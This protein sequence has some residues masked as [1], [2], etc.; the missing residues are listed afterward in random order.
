LGKPTVAPARLK[1]TDGLI[2]WSRPALA[3]KNQ[4][5]AMEPWPRNYTFWH[6][7]AGPAVRLIL[8]PVSIAEGLAARA[9]GTVVEASGGRLVIAAGLGAAA[10]DGIQ[11]AGKRMMGVGEFLRGYAV[12]AGD[13]F[14]AE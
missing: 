2:D 1:K 6:P 5:R 10:P 4:I 12:R 7:A 11:P 3:V 13:W 14:G 8:G 9:A